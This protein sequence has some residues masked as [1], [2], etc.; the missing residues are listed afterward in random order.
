MFTELPRAYDHIQIR[1]RAF[2]IHIENGISTSFVNGRM[3]MIMISPS[4]EIHGTEF[5]FITLR[6]LTK[7]LRAGQCI[8]WQASRKIEQ[9]V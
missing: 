2:L 6:P 9:T 8:S 7:T 3:V 1:K 4:S 5:P